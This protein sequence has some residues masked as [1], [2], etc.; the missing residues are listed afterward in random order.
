[1]EGVDLVRTLE[2]RVDETLD[3]LLMGV[4]RVALLDFPNYANVGDSAIWLATV[5]YLHARGI[6]VSYTAG[7]ENFDAAHARAKLGE[8]VVLLT[9]GGN[10]GDVWEAHQAFREHVVAALPDRR[11]IQL[12]QSIQFHNEANVRRA[13]RCFDAHPDLTILVRDR[14]SLDVASNTFRAAVHLCPDM[15]FSLGPL[16]R[17]GA[18][19]QPIVRL[20][21]Q[22]KEGRASATERAVDWAVQPS[23]GA[24]QVHD[25]LSR[26]LV[27]Y[28]RR[29]RALRRPLS[30]L[31][32][33]LA[34]GRLDY[35]IRLLSAGETVIT[36]RLHGHVLCLLLGIRHFLFGDRYGKLERFRDAWTANA[37]LGTW[38]A[39]PDAAERE[40]RWWVERGVGVGT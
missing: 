21:R 34:R 40:A 18:P 13:R 29:A 3:P 38:C 28:P 37:T 36:D 22:D 31:Y 17:V 12:P 4:D 8:G 24:R 7:R 23:N 16:G 5:A 6:R 25:V 14:V 15:A 19:E 11:I 2:R 30:A 9:G 27:R 39:G 33:R 10:L 1:M 35:G 32:D 20:V 26:T